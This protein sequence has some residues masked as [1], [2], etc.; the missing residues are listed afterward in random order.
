MVFFPER[1]SSSHSPWN[2]YVGY[3]SKISFILQPEKL[4]HSIASLLFFLESE[5]YPTTMTMVLPPTIIPNTDRRRMM[6]MHE[7]PT[8]VRLVVDIGGVNIN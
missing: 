5:Q 3:I 4:A 6:P 2:S 7:Q 8:S 1:S